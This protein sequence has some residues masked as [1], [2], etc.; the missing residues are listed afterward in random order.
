[1]EGKKAQVRFD[2]TTDW[3]GSSGM[4]YVMVSVTSYI[5]IILYQ[6]G[7]TEWES[8]RQKRRERSSG[9]PTALTEG[10]DVVKT[11]TR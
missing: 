2:R 3:R 10:F 11:L 6:Y 4:G 9:R 8:L 5:H 7:Y 1:M